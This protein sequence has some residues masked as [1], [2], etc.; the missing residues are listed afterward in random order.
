MNAFSACREHV[1]KHVEGGKRWKQCPPID[2]KEYIA[3][4]GTLFNVRMR[5]E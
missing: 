3:K 2:D 5:R 1:W 4:V